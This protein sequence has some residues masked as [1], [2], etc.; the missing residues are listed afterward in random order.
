MRTIASTRYVQVSTMFSGTKF[1]IDPGETSRPNTHG[2]TPTPPTTRRYVRAEPGERDRAKPATP[3]ST[4]MT[5]CSAETWKIPST[6]AP[7]P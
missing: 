1:D 2:S 4:W 3:R 7:E 5:S 6:I